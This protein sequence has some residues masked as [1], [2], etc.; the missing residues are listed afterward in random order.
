[1]RTLVIVAVGFSLISL[2]VSEVGAAG[3][4]KTHHR[5]AKLYYRQARPNIDRESRYPDSSGWYP[6]DASKLPFGSAI[7]WD[8][9]RRERRLGGAGG[10]N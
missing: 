1:M 3:Y 2:P 5:H 6:R 9:M 8:Q 10:A 4:S 7:W